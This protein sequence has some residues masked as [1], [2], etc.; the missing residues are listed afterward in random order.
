MEVEQPVAANKRG[1]LNHLR[2]HMLVSF[3]EERTAR[4][5]MHPAMGALLLK[6]RGLI[7]KCGEGSS[8]R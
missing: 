5:N 4:G 1:N 6:R 2:R 8:G 7:E 3:P